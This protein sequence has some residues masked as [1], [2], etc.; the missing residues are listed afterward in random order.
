V[1]RAQFEIREEPRWGAMSNRAW[2]LKKWFGNPASAKEI[3]GWTP[4]V[5]L[6]EG[7]VHTAN[8]LKVKGAPPRIEATKDTSIPVRL[9]AIIACY[10]DSQAIPHMHRRLTE[11]F[12]KI[13]VDYEI[14]FV[15]DCS[16]DDTAQVLEKLCRE[17]EHVVSLEH[18]RNFGSQAAFLSG[19]EVSTGH[20]VILLDGDM[21]DPPELIPEFFA[22]WM[23]GYEVVYGRR[24][25]R[26]ASPVMQVMYKA[27]YRLFRKMAYINIPADAGDF[28]LIDRRVVACLKALPETDQFLRGLRA[29]VGFRQTG[30]D[31]VRPERMFGRSTN[32]WL[33]NLWWARK[34]IFSFSFAPLDVLLYGGTFMTACAFLFLAIQFVYRLFHP[35][36]PHGTATIIILILL[37]GGTNILAAS[38]LGE[39]IGK[40]LEETKRRPRFIRHRIMM[41]DRKFEKQEE[42]DNFVKRRADRAMQWMGNPVQTPS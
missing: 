12:R 32:N 3:L 31:Y 8:W 33:K 20:A 5:E 40:V 22:K 9:S 11:A 27:F 2:D 18:S 26:E 10:K 15:N 42:I 4:R 36:M 23:E 1:A 19:M 38:I 17:D 7:L 37:F 41:G 35:E 6:R 21:Q 39:Y 14:L 29:W 34:A 16:P 30:V 25:K 28:S 13:N 24:V